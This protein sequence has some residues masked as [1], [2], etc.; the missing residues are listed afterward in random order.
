MV[1]PKAAFDF[2]AFIAMLGSALETGSVQGG[3]LADFN[4]FARCAFNNCVNSSF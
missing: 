2:N 4:V 3:C 1:S